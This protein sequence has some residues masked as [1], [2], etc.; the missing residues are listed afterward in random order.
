MSK[1]A[2]GLREERRGEGAVTG[3]CHFVISYLLQNAM[4]CGPYKAA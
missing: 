3:Y 2:W 1:G 4:S